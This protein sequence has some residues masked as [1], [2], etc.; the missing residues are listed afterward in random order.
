MPISRDKLTLE[1]RCMSLEGSA[2][3]GPCFLVSLTF[4]QFAS[5]SERGRVKVLALIRSA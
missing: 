4:C 1:Q 5:T 2:F 3:A